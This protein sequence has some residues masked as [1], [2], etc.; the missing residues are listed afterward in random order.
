M[1]KLPRLGVEATAPPELYLEDVPDAPITEGGIIALVK[2]ILS[3]ELDENSD[4]ARKIM[5]GS[6]HDELQDFQ[7]RELPSGILVK[8]FVPETGQTFRGWG[9]SKEAA[10]EDVLYRLVDGL[11]LSDG[12]VEI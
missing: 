4:E 6:L 2:L 7:Y 11:E 10:A 8:V 5:M 1:D 12:P 9:I 3:L